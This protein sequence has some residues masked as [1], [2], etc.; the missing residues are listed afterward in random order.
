MSQIFKQSLKSSIFSYAGV[1]IGFITTGLLMPTFL[2]PED[3][4]TIKLTQSYGQIIGVIFALGT[5]TAILKVGPF[6]HTSKSK[7]HGLFL[8]ALALSTFSVILL[9]LISPVTYKVLLNYEEDQTFLDFI[10]PFILLIATG[11]IFF[12]LLDSYSNTLGYIAISS[13]GKDFAMRIF[14]LIIIA[15][16]VF[17]S[18]SFTT[19][20][21]V[22]ALIYFAPA[23]ILIFHS[24]RTNNASLKYNPIIRTKDFIKTFRSYTLIGFVNKINLALVLT[25]DSIMIGKYDSKPAVGIYS[26][27]FY[28]ASILL[29]PAKAI[30]KNT[31]PFVAEGIHNN[32]RETVNRIYQKT[33][34][35]EMIIG[36]V[37]ASGLI[38]NTPIIFGLLK[39]EYAAG[40]LVIILIS[41][42]NF[43]NMAAGN[44]FN[45]LELSSSFVYRII[46]SL[47]FIGLMVS[48]NIVLI[49][50][51]GIT[52]AA[53]ASLISTFIYQLL[54]VIVLYVK[55]KFNLLSP[56]YFKVLG[57][58]ISILALSVA[59]SIYN[60]NILAGITISLA[61]NGAFIG[62]LYSKNIHPEFSNIIN[63]VV[64][65]YL[66]RK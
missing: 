51:Y 37:L 27:V 20:L 58:S 35:T 41:L 11:N 14:N 46:L 22:L 8:L 39:D 63:S 23:V 59:T 12:Y 47:I 30:S 19:L 42:A 66:S 32:N 56:T 55:E 21:L 6:F 43:I 13:F 50:D 2:D 28:F 25:L 36:V 10:F 33:A 34:L 18:I 16:Y 7:T 1:L 38:F 3:I 44:N 31:V 26:V 65:K 5:P 57:V 4:G 45:I 29:I 52:G 40:H 54:G 17:T 49:P 24:F 62:W 9:Y 53:I 64:E 15:I 48:L 61:V 60:E